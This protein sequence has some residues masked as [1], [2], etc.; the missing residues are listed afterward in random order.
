MKLFSKIT[1]ASACD[2]LVDSAQRKLSFAV[3]LPTKFPHT[4][5]TLNGALLHS[6]HPKETPLDRLGLEESDTDSEGE[7]EDGMD[8]VQK[9]WRDMKVR[10]YGSGGGGTIWQVKFSIDV[11]RNGGAGVGG[12]GR[13]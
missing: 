5:V 3:T 10:K 4:G 1:A 9:I 2:M 12:T 13:A 6:Y 11:N 8:E 7:A